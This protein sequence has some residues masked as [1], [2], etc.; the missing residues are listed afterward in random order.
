MSYG[1]E[2]KGKIDA[3]YR[4]QYEKLGEAKTKALE[5][6]EKHHVP[7]VVYEILGRYTPTTHWEEEV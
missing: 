5:L 7:V 6:C 1:I 3:A 2:P 4:W